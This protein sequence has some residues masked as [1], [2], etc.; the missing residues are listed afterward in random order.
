MRRHGAVKHAAK[1]VDDATTAICIGVE[2]VDGRFWWPP[3][4]RLWL[5]FLGLI[6]LSKKGVAS[7]AGVGSFLGI[8]QWFDLLNRLKPFTD[9][10]AAVRI[11][12][13]KRYQL[14]C[15]MN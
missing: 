4:S 11:G 13:H 2:M 5:L 10:L 14:Q 6:D 3:G 1:D 9:L 7:P 12:S 8:L 15:C